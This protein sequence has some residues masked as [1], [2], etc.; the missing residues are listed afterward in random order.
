LGFLIEP[1][2]DRAS[3][4]IALPLTLLIQ[5][6]LQLHRDRFETRPSGDRNQVGQAY[7]FASAL[8]A[9]SAL[10]EEMNARSFEPFICEERARLAR[11]AEDSA[12]FER[13]LREAH[14]LYAEMGATGHAERL[15]REL[16]L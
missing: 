5:I 6:G 12:A 8:D 1:L 13:E 16:G 10:A 2:G 3:R 15:A 14:R 11:A 7:A 4:D 9:A